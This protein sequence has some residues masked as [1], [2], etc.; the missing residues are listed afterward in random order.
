[1]RVNHNSKYEHLLG[2][3]VVVDAGEK[4]Q[5]MVGNCNTHHC[6]AK[7]YRAYFFLT[8]CVKAE[9]A[10][11]FAAVEERGL[12]STLPALLAALLPVVSLRCGCFLLMILSPLASKK[13]GVLGRRSL[14]TP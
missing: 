14:R 13:S 6:H 10:A 9:P 12:P 4:A 11:D 3:A 5:A 8:T 2:V 1:M 7:T